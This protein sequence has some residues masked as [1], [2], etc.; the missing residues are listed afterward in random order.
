MQI[1]ELSDTPFILGAFER[2]LV[3]ERRER[4][5]IRSWCCPV[6]EQLLLGDETVERRSA[7]QRQYDGDS[8]RKGLFSIALN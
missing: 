4:F 7:Q 5:K 3:I 1:D 6:A 8:I 2:S